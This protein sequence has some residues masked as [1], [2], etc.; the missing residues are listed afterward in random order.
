MKIY[1]VDT[2]ASGG[3]TFAALKRLALLAA[4]GNKIIFAGATKEVLNQCYQDMQ[5]RYPE[6]YCVCIHSDTQEAKSLPT[7]QKFMRSQWQW[8]KGCVLF[9]TQAALPFVPRKGW[10]LVVD[11]VPNA[12]DS[13]ELDHISRGVRQSLN[14]IPMGPKYCVIRPKRPGYWKSIVQGKKPQWVT[15]PQSGLQV[16]KDYKDFAVLLLKPHYDVWGITEE[17]SQTSSADPFAKKHIFTELRPD[18]YAGFDGVPTIMAAMIKDTLLYHLWMINHGVIW[19]ENKHIK[20]RHNQHNNGR[21]L[22]IQYFSERNFSKY[23]R[24]SDYVAGSGLGPVLHQMFRAVEHQF[25]AEDFAYMCNKDRAEHCEE[26]FAGRGDRLPNKPHGL[27]CYQ[28]LHRVAIFSALN[29]KAAHAAWLDFRGISGDEIKQALSCQDTYQA[30]MRISLRNAYD[31]TPKSAFVPDRA[32]A[33]YIA[34]VFPGCQIK[35]NLL[36]LD[37]APPAS[38]NRGRDVQSA[39][40]KRDYRLE[41]ALQLGKGVFL[42]DSAEKKVNEINSP[43]FVPRPIDILSV[44]DTFGAPA[45]NQDVPLGMSLFRN[46]HSSLDRR[47]SAEKKANEINSPIFVRRP[48]DILSLSDTFGAVALNQDTPLDTPL[49]MSLFRNKHSSDPFALL[50]WT[51]IE[52]FVSQLRIWHADSVPS[53][54][55]NALISPSVFDPELARQAGDFNDKGKLKKRGRAAV[56]S[57]IGIWLDNDWGDMKK[58]QFAELF[59]ELRMVICNSYSSEP[60]MEKY[61]VWIPTTCGMSPD[62]YMHITTQIRD[63]V[64]R[65]GAGYRS[66]QWASLWFIKYA[67]KHGNMNA[68]P[69]YLIH[70]FDWSKTYPEN[71]MYLPCQAG[72]GPEASFFLDLQGGLRAPLDVDKWITHSIV[73]KRP[74]L[75]DEPLPADLTPKAQSPI[76][77]SQAKARL[78]AALQQTNTTSRQMLIDNAIASWHMSDISDHRIAGFFRLAARLKDIGLSRPENGDILRAEATQ[79]AQRNDITRILKTLYR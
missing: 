26:A 70:G 63:R 7:I 62:L 55:A 44:W 16:S 53:K 14:I 67:E 15:S 27:N 47:D 9:I 8:G 6:V 52:S 4:A 19:E 22:E 61:R 29:L 45:P 42:L 68:D 59:P 30:V 64:E 56:R 13:L 24:D 34:R 36:G 57:S 37:N 1:Y 23:L 65:H 39:E 73:N 20:P 25:G 69:P 78:V 33:E 5:E 3:K 46:K 43:I 38:K 51:D 2:I 74:A 28:H 72:A 54:E 10:R 71:M 11:E 31:T 76:P 75:P 49:G 48:I 79:S 35:R 50:R 12:T 21:L 60:D 41:Q 17:W 66:A 58:E 77:M 32:S 18:C 40:R